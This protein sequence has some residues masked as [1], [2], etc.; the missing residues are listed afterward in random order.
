MPVYI[1]RQ[2]DHLAG[3]AHRLGT[4]PDAIWG[5]P[6]NADLRDRRGDG[7]VLHPGDLLHVPP[8]PEPRTASL[9]AGDTHAFRA[10]IPRTRVSLRLVSGG[11]PIS[12]EP[13]RADADGIRTTG[14]TSG[15]GRVELE[16][17]VTTRRVKLHLARR[18]E[19]LVLDVGGLD[20][21]SEISGAQMRLS[22]LG[23]Y[24]GPLDGVLSDAVGDALRAFQRASRLPE[25][26][27]LDEATLTALRDAYGC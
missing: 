6:A 18:H 7:A 23:H 13:F 2:G 10:S 21:A 20:P 14:S 16:V 24:R 25:S 1:V 4:T 19:T 12:G 15:E 17:R 9:R 26:G 22:H 8:P 27:G 11:Q 5:L 3:I